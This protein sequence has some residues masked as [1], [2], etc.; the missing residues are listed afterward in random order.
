[1]A[2]YM[3]LAIS[4]PQGYLWLASPPLVAYSYLASLGSRLPLFTQPH[5]ATWHKSLDVDQLSRIGWLG[6]IGW[7]CNRGLLRSVCRQQL[8]LRENVQF[9]WMGKLGREKGFQLRGANI[10][11]ITPY[12]SYL[13]WRGINDMQIDPGLTVTSFELVEKMG[14]KSMSQW[15][16]EIKTTAGSA[17]F[18]LLAK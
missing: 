9:N 8:L 3:D 18:V 16:S 10:R 5:C 4:S 12:T 6:P 15:G 13:S 2:S 17:D 1:M 7:N 11:L 14:R